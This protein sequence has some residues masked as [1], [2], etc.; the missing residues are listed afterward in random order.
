[1]E[2][3]QARADLE[4]IISRLAVAYPDTNSGLSL[5]ARPLRERYQVPTEM[6]ATMMGAVAFVLLI[7]YANIANLLLA[8]SIR[9]TREIAV[10]TALGATRWRLVRQLLVECVLIAVLGGALGFALSLYG[11]NEI[12]VAFD[13]LE[14]GAARGTTR[15]YWVDVTPNAIVFGFVGLLSIGSALAFGLL[16]AWQTSR[17]DINETLKDEGRGTGGGVRGRRWST[18][19]L[20][21]QLALTLVLLSGAGLLWRGFLD[22]YQQDTVIDATGIVTM[23]LGLPV[24]KYPTPD[25]RRRFLEQLNQRLTAMTVFSSVTMASHV[26]MEFGAPTRELFIDDVALAPGEKPPLVSYMLTGNNYFGLLKL[27][28]VRG[29]AID[30]ADGRRGQEGAVVDERLASQFFPQADPIGRRIRLGASGVWFTIVGIAKTVPQSGPRPETRP[31]VYAALEAEPAPEGRAAIMVK[32][33]LA[34]ASARLREEVRAMDPT[35]PLFA[36]E[37]LEAALARGRFPTRMISTW[38]GALAVVALALAAVGVFAMTAHAVA[39][40]TH[41]IGVRMAL[42]ADAGAVVRLFARRTTLQLGI[43]ITVGLAG[44]FAI[45]RLIRST[46]DPLTLLI[47]T[48]LLTGVAMT[49]TLVPARRAARVDPMVALRAE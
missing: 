49:A 22:Q 39:Q 20:T 10:R 37:T 41:E 8:R 12:A 30:A 7:A 32:G 44:A 9:R 48:T 17:S 40:R 13:V 46:A 31:V 36:I 2:L 11:T 14:P 27:P 25:D 28:I 29:R 43:G 38:F 26:P 18:A 6:L 3:P 21:A 19:L 5:S 47:V 34:A 24:K 42:G 23:R 4:A 1:M 33:P 16:P 15:P 45:A 35:L